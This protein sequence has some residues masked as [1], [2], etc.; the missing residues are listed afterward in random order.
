MLNLFISFIALAISS[1]VVY[2]MAVAARS[3]KAGVAQVGIS[4]LTSSAQPPQPDAR[5]EAQRKPLRVL[6][7]GW[8]F[9]PF[10]SGGLG[11][12]CEG[13]ARALSRGN[14]SIAFV[15]PRRL[16]VS[17]PFARFLF[18]DADLKVYEAGSLLTPYAASGSYVQDEDGN[19]LYDADIVGEVRRYARFGAKVA[20]REP[21]DVI[22]AHDWLSFAA[23]MAAKKVSGKP[24]VAHVH[25]TEFERTGGR[26]D[27]RIYDIERAGLHAADRIIAVSNRTKDLIVSRYDVPAGKVEVVWNG[28]DSAAEAASAEPTRFDA[29]K[30]AGNRL[31]LFMGRIT[32]QKGP[33]HL[34]KAA[35]RALEKDSRIFF[36]FAGDGDMRGQVM[37]EAAALGI[38]NRVLFPGFLRGDEQREAYR[39]ADLFVMPS[40]AEPFGL[41]ALEALRSGTPALISRQ[42]GVAEAV[43]HALKTDFWDA[44][45]MAAKMLA[46]LSLPALSGELSKNGMR[47]AATLSW[48]RAASRVRDIMD[49][50]VPEPLFAYA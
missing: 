5:G 22:Y 28:I 23:G 18:P 8:E 15:L 27:K 42:S 29:L 40:V 38:A 33:D 9:P 4:S 36:V 11:V 41:T 10:N 12:A 25:A 31:V 3:R 30:A 14:A 24:L 34:L 7:F 20:R 17:S 47:E 26:I 48:E 19:P 1:L 50:L 37:Q 44:D 45:D 43:K 21:H 2:G 46:A 35:K 49:E 39:A 6:M 16:G 13:L 32:L